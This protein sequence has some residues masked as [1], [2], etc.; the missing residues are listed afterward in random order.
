MAGAPS[1]SPAEAYV[2]LVETWA[3]TAGPDAFS[4]LGHYHWERQGLHPTKA[5]SAPGLL[6]CVGILEPALVLS[7][8][9]ELVFSLLKAALMKVMVRTTSRE[10]ST[11]T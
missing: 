10:P 3:R 1:A 4:R 9:A 2:E 11:P 7:P 5:A 8:R 6:E